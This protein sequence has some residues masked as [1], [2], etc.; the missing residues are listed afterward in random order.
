[1][2]PATHAWLDGLR[3]SA[4]ALRGASPPPPVPDPAAAAAERMILAAHLATWLDAAPRMLDARRL[5][6]GATAADPDPAIVL[7]TSPAGI[8]LAE[9]LLARG[10]PVARMLAPRTACVTE[11]EYRRWCMRHP[12]EHNR[13]H[14]NHW[15]WIK[16]DVPPRRD[17]EFARHPRGP[18]DRY[19]LHRTGTAGAGAADGRATHLWRFDGRHAAL[20]EAG[21]VEG[22]APPPRG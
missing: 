17:A 11:R 2:Q 21:V 1:M 10:D 19:W 18:E 7:T 15:S 13:L 4:A 20:L 5:A 6:P 9:E 3:A 8:V 22:V 14:V 16:T 12:D